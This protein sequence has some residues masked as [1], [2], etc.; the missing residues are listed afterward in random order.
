MKKIEALVAGVFVSL[1]F[2]AAALAQEAGQWSFGLRAGPSWPTDTWTK[3]TVTDTDGSTPG[4]GKFKL[5]TGPMVSGKMSY[6]LTDH[7]SL[8]LN[9]EWDTH[10]YGEKTICL[11]CNVPASNETFKIGGGRLNTFSFMPFVE[12]RPMKFGDFS[13]YLSLGMGVNFNSIQWRFVSVGRAANTFAAKVGGGFDY[14]LTKNLAFNTEV[15]YKR[16]EGGLRYGGVVNDAGQLEGGYAR[17]RSHASTVSLLFG[18]RYHFPKPAGGIVEREKIVERERI[19]EKPVEKIVT[20]EVIK[21]VPVE[22]IVKVP[23][24]ITVERIVFSDIAFDY[25]KSTLTDLGK[26]RVYLIA[27]KLKE[28]KNVKV[29]VEGH[30]D[31]IGTDEYNQALG[32]RRSNTVREELVRLGISADRMTTAS[33]GES[34]PLLDMQ[35]DWARAVNR[36]VEFEISGDVPKK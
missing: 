23:E 34:Q 17:G 25:D 20:K 3:L 35:T 31:F 28:N 12:V 29:V 19:V 16:N 7:F 30:T 9:G 13:P 27:Q 22:K 5:K 1:F 36:R 18:L 11:D 2:A 24:Y 4:T 33:Y 32:L 10:K 21:E 6:A 8:G 26:G 14:F 15:G